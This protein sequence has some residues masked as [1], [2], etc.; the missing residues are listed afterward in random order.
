[1]L[2]EEGF[3]GL[4]VAHFVLGAGNDEQ[5]FEPTFDGLSILQNRLGVPILHERHADLP[6]RVL[7]PDI[8]FANAAIRCVAVFVDQQEN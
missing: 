8:P 7:V 5:S 2:F 1:M 6:A 4:Q 3:A